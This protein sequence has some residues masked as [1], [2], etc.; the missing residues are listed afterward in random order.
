MPVGLGSGAPA[1]LACPR[2][3]HS[4]GILHWRPALIL[5]CGDFGKILLLRSTLIA[6][7]SSVKWG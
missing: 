6:G 3:R 7:S 2:G 4:A 1:K 5:P